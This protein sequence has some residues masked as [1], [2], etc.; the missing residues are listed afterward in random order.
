MKIAVYA[1]SKNE[2]QFVKTFCK[3]SS[4]ADLIIVGDTGS[5]DDTRGLLRE[6]GAVVH[7]ICISPWRFDRARDAV[8]A[9][10][11]GYVDVCISLDLDEKLE[12]GW[13]EEIER[14]WVPGET[15]RM[16]YVFDWGQGVR[17]YSDKIHSRSGY[18][19][20]HPCHECL[21]PDKRTDEKLVRSDKTLITHHPDPT[22]SRSQ[23]LDLLKMSVEED[24][25]CPRNA[26]YYGR[27]LTYYRRWDL[28]IDQLKR[29]LAMPEAVWEIERAYAMRL[30]GESMEALKLDGWMNWYRKGCAE[31]PTMREPWVAL[32]DACYRQSLWEECFGAALCALRLTERPLTYTSRDESWGYKPHDLAAIAAYRM[33]MM[34][35]ARKHGQRALDIEP[36]NDRLIKNME[37]YNGSN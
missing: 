25:H 8:L 20:H 7:D 4:E 31:A 28:A 34:E 26:F 12:P 14:L 16:Q 15:T 6:S 17:F 11:P 19:W 23:Y 22:K 36:H 18:R 13:R 33:G 2:E 30:I 29:Y 21:R 32:A 1:I 27:E 10:V 5:T 35:E 24:P 37:Y 9:L 3:S